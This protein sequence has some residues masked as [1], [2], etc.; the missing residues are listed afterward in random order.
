MLVGNCWCERLV[1]K[2]KVELIFI[3][4]PILS[5]NIAVKQRLST[6]NSNWKYGWKSCIINYP[7][8]YVYDILQEANRTNA[9]CILE[10]NT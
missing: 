9:D 2:S 6:V 1:F 7:I 3:N 4:H 8:F 5:I 10:M